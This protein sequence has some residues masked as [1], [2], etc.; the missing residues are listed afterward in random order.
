[1]IIKDYIPGGYRRKE[2]K[3]Y[4]QYLRYNYSEI[5]VDKSK[6]NNIIIDKD[7]QKMYELKI[8]NKDELKKHMLYI[9]EFFEDLERFDELCDEEIYYSFHKIKQKNYTKDMNNYIENKIEK[10]KN[11]I[12]KNL[13]NIENFDELIRFLIYYD[14]NPKKINIDKKFYDIEN[15]K[16]DL[17]NTNIINIFP[18]SYMQIPII[19]KILKF[20]LSEKDIKVF[21]KDQRV[22][23][24]PILS[25]LKYKN[26]KIINYNSRCAGVNLKDVEKELECALNIVLDEIPMINFN[27]YLNSEYY[28]LSKVNTLKS[29][30][31][32][33]VYNVNSKSIKSII[34]KVK[35]TQKAVFTGVERSE[36]TIW[37]FNKDGYLNQYSQTFIPSNYKY[38]KNDENV[39]IKR[40]KFLK[41]MINNNIKEDIVY[42]D[43]YYS[44]DTYEKEKYIPQKSSNSVLMRGFYIKNTQ[45]FDI[46]PYLAQDHKKDLIDIREV[47][48]SI[49]KNS[50]YINFL[51]FATPKI[52]NLYNS[53]RSE[54]EKIK[55]RDFFIDYYFDGI[56]ET[57]PLYNKGAIF[58][59][60]DGTI[61]FD[62]VKAENGTIKLNDYTI[63]FDENNINNPNQSINIITPNSDYDDFENF[64]KYKK[65]VGGDRYNIIIVNNK[66]INIKFSGV[67]QP[68]LGIVIS[69]DKNEFKKVSKVLNLK[70]CGNK[71][72]YDQKIN[73]EIIINKN[74][75]YNKIFGGGTLL[76]K[77]GK[78]LVKTQKEA[79]EN[80]KVEG[81]Y[82]PLSM[83]T[84]ETQVQE[85]LRGPRTIIGNDH[86]NGF[87]F[88]VFSGRTKESKG[89]RFDEIV[90]MVENEI[91]D[92]KN[93]MN[94]DGGASSCLGFIKDKEFFELSYPC[95]S[96][97]TSAG[98]VR[99]VNSMLLINK[100]GD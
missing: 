98:M 97:Y 35:R 46:L 63:N 32:C 95:T 47:C 99:P 79:Y 76:Y 93:I 75:N 91:K 25:D 92:V 80:F 29:Q 18:G 77:E 10:N 49:H 28:L 30:R 54:E 86:K 42:I 96:N 36:N 66:I 21:I 73:I 58:F 89:V 83:Q 13:K 17:K 81:W 74:K 5:M 65:Y 9:E 34:K 87:F 27:G 57:F 31:Y 55:D 26:F 7:L 85:W 44:L 82:N 61:E 11:Y 20:Y 22:I 39:F 59:K 70:K 38:E 48:K 67:V 56:K 84:Q 62:R 52:I 24:E 94:I 78:N 14:I 64:R 90:K 51:Y 19:E 45:K 4:F 60:K 72:L 6:G 69:L 33:G 15:L 37:P 23:S 53:F 68:S 40:E 41:N 50:F 2:L 12:Y 8:I 1:M 100:K 16:N 88:I 71:Y 3:G 43:S